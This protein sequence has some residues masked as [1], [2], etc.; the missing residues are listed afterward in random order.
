M[1]VDVPCFA[2]PQS[3]PASLHCCVNTVFDHDSFWCLIRLTV[4]CPGHT[5]TGQ[6][7]VADLCHGSFH[8]ITDVA[9]AHISCHTCFFCCCFHDIDC[10][11]SIRCELVRCIAVSFFVS[12]NKCLCLFIICISCKRCQKLT[13]SASFVSKFLTAS[14][15]S[16]PSHPKN[17]G[18]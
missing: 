18:A 2:L 16:R 6:T 14:R 17:V 1:P 8:C 15:P 10:I 4:C 9:Y 12:R 7:I 13:P 3:T 5:F 11:V